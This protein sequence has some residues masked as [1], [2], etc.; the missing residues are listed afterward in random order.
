MSTLFLPE[1]ARPSRMAHSHVEWRPKALG[2]RNTSACGVHGQLGDGAARK[3]HGAPSQL[4]GG[5]AC[6]ARGAPS[7]L[8]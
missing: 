2:R 7:Q 3:A 4:G 6:K 5:A 8:G 1:P